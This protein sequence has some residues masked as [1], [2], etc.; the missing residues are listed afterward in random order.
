MPTNLAA[1]IENPESSS[2]FCEMQ[3]YDKL[4]KLIKAHGNLHITQNNSAFMVTLGPT[5]FALEKHQFSCTLTLNNQILCSDQAIIMSQ[6]VAILFDDPQLPIT[7]QAQSHPSEHLL[8]QALF[9]DGYSIEP[10]DRPQ[11]DRFLKM[12][13]HFNHKINTVSVI[14]QSISH[15]A[16]QQILS[17]QTHHHPT[18]ETNQLSIKNTRLSPLIELVDHRDLN[19]SLSDDH[20]IANIKGIDL[21]FIPEK[22][23]LRLDFQHISSLGVSATEFVD[24]MRQVF[25][26]DNDTPIDYK[27]PNPQRTMRVWAQINKSNKTLVNKSLKDE[28]LRE[29]LELLKTIQQKG[30]GGVFRNNPRIF[31]S[32]TFKGNEA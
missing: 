20:L 16:L 4:L 5:C 18:L 17:I 11:K 24:R 19:I 9:Y 3:P 25:H 32:S 28:T 14:K 8:W 27:D 26:R 22:Y 2:L 7:I 21:S 30:L 1:L 31:D 15:S 10:H 12:A 23:R 6:L 29:H 13:Q